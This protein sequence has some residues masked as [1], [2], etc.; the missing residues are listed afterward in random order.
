MTAACLATLV[1]EDK[2]R[3]DDP[4]SKHL[5]GFR[6]DDFASL[7]NVRVLRLNQ[8]RLGGLED[9]RGLSAKDAASRGLAL[10]DA[11]G[12]PVALVAA[13]QQPNNDAGAAQ[14]YTLFFERA[15][16]QGEP[17]RFVFSGRRRALLEVPFVLENVPLP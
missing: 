2:L 11:K 12:A 1:D 5:P 3:W 14:V 10:L 16:D 4:V 6:L 7:P 13:E 17:A 15:K 8:K 9:R